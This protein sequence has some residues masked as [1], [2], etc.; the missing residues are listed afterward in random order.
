MSNIYKLI[1]D[2]LH[3]AMISWVRNPRRPSSTHTWL[4]FFTCF[5]S[6]ENR[7]VI[8]ENS[9][10]ARYFKQLYWRMGHDSRQQ[11]KSLEQAAFSFLQDVLDE[12]MFCINKIL[13]GWSSWRS[14][15]AALFMRHPSGYKN[16]TECP[17]TIDTALIDASG[18][19]RWIF[20]HKSMCVR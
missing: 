4:Y 14:G 17:V 13:D 6:Y 10:S 9:T 19:L 12:P 8:I 16:Y 11:V 18:Y 20:G 1:I 3:F 2:S 5:Y 7:K 15:I